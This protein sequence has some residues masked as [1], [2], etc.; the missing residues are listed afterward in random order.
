[1]PFMPGFRKHKT[2]ACYV[3]RIIAGYG[4]F[5]IL[6]CNSAGYGLAVRRGRQPGTQ[7][8]QHRIRYENIARHKIHL[9]SGAERR[10][11]L[12]KKLARPAFQQA[13]LQKEFQ[14]IFGAINLCRETRNLLAH[15]SWDYSKNGL[16]IASLEDAARK[17]GVQSNIQMR[18]VPRQSLRYVENYFWEVFQALETINK[19]CAVRNGLLRPPEPTKPTIPSRRREHTFLFP[20]WTTP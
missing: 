1:M 13:N 16:Q 19:I 18:D 3:G 17:G 10:L 14:E 12:A 4:E 2:D 5:E 11:T 20:E 8:G 15:S 9:V 6:F 7:I